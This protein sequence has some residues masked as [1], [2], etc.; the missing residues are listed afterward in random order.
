MQELLDEKKD[1]EELEKKAES[2]QQL[3]K[4]VK[5]ARENWAA[6]QSAA[7]SGSAKEASG[8]SEP[9]SFANDSPSQTRDDWE[10][11]KN[12]EGAQSPPLDEL[13]GM[14]GLEEVKQAFM[15]I[16][17]RVD[18]NVRQ[19]VSLQ[20]QRYSAVMLGNPGTGKLIHHLSRSHSM[21]PYSVFG[22]LG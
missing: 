15:D 5:Q 7:S 1:R 14:I 3:R 13:M 4:S 19:N 6:V 12:T 11:L 18:T 16:K 8:G 22:K 2:L 9:V 17:N 10:Y 21:R 20:K